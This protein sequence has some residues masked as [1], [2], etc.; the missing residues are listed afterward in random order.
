MGGERVGE[1]EEGDKSAVFYRSAWQDA[2]KVEYFNIS[3]VHICMCAGSTQPQ[4]KFDMRSPLA[5]SCR[6]YNS[7]LLPKSPPKSG[8]SLDQPQSLTQSDSRSQLPRVVR[9]L[10]HYSELFQ[11][12][13]MTICRLLC[14]PLVKPA[15]NAHLI[16]SAASAPG[17]SRGDAATR[18]RCDPDPAHSHAAS[19]ATGSTYLSSTYPS[20]RI[21]TWTAQRHTFHHESGRLVTL[22]HF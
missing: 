14:R 18:R 15:K 20:M 16:R 11:A 12:V 7:S 4:Y 2:G 10:T 3:H 17:K 19:L 13:A 1:E 5:I 22:H 6:R 8:S 21:L 9:V